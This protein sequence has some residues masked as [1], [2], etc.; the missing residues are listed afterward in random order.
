LQA[1]NKERDIYLWGGLCSYF[2]LLDRADL[3]RPSVHETDKKLF[4]PPSKTWLETLKKRYT[5]SLQCANCNEEHLGRP[6]QYCSHQGVVQEEDEYPMVYAFDY[7]IP[8]PGKVKRWSCCGMGEG[9]SGRCEN[10]P[11]AAV[12]VGKKPCTTFIQRHFM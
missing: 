10:N 1:P 2:N 12:P 5:R 4:Y 7:P 11:L 8:F 9:Q 3:C 6:N